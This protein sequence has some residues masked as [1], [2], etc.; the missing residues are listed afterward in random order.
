[1]IK[2]TGTVKAISEVAGD[3]FLCLD[4][5]HVTITPHVG[6]TDIIIPITG[7]I[8]DELSDDMV[9]NII[10]KRMS[11]GPGLLYF[12]HFLADLAYCESPQDITLLLDEYKLDT[13]IVNY[14][15]CEYWAPNES[16]F[17]ELGEYQYEPES[18]D[19]NKKIKS[20]F[21]NW[22]TKPHPAF[23]KDLKEGD[24]VKYH[25]VEGFGW[26]HRYFLSKC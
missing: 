13:F 10:T 18:E 5:R 9:K 15:W 2:G 22:I 19:S 3:N 4:V 23:I 11:F 17:G 16:K 24:R 7:T 20:S 8:K 6:S 12:G 26:R 14:Y 25:D 21:F 1:M